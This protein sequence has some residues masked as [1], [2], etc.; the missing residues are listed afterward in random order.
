M[1]FRSKISVLFSNLSQMIFLS[2]YALYAKILTRSNRNNEQK[3]LSNILTIRWIDAS[4]AFAKKKKISSDNCTV[5]VVR[6][7][8]HEFQIHF[9]LQI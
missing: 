6:F 4:T 1:H 3:N 7:C 2:A 5:Y 9:S 8:G